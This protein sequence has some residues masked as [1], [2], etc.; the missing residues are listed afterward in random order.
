MA[1]EDQNLTCIPVTS[2]EHQQVNIRCGRNVH[3]SNQ[4]ESNFSFSTEM[5]RWKVNEAIVQVSPQKQATT[6][7]LNHFNKEHP[8]DDVERMIL[9][10]EFAQI[11]AVP[12]TK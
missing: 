8:S 2:S 7:L 12:A 1:L 6:S 10:E 9:Q 11:A 5:E 4:S 3:K